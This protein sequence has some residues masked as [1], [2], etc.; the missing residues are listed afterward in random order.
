MSR[1]KSA[2]KLRRAV[3]HALASITLAAIGWRT[4]P[5][6]RSATL[7]LGDLYRDVQRESPKLQAARALVRAAEAR[8][9]SSKLPPDPQLQVG[10]MNYTVP[11]LRPM[12]PLGMA[13]LQVMQMV[14]VAGKLGLSGR[15]ST[16]QAGAQ[17]ERANEVSWELRSQAAMAFYELYQTEQRLVVMR[18]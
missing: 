6:Q 7:V 2:A 10:F 13:Q 1:L 18:E 4:L 8:I 5:A 16:A 12:D 3:W 17:Q 14:P 9:P 11:G 15:V